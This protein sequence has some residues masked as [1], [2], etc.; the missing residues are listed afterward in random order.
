MFSQFIRTKFN[1]E[2]E[3]KRKIKLLNCDKFQPH[4]FIYLI[5]IQYLM[6][7]LSC[8]LI[9]LNVYSSSVSRSVC[10]R[11]YERDEE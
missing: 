3:L 6:R 4:D 2:N 10:T 7:C 5:I 1:C 9:K 11:I 8:Q